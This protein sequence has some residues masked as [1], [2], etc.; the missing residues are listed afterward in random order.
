MV[1]LATLA[2]ASC[3]N[4]RDAFP[5]LEGDYPALEIPTERPVIFS[6]G[7]ICT[8]LNERD[9]TISPDGNEIFY[10]L[11]AGKTVTIMYS[12]FNGKY[13]EEPVVAPFASDKRFSYFEPCF[14]PDGNSVWFL[15][16]MPAMDK[17]PKPGWAYQNIFVS[18]RKGDGT[19]D[20][21]HDPGGCINEGAFQFYPS[22]TR[23]RTVY[24]SRTDPSTGRHSLFRSSY[25][26]GMYSKCERL[27]EPVNSDS[28]MPFNV[29]VSPDESFIIACISSISVE[30][31]PD[32]SNYF[33]FADDGEGGWSGPVPLGPDIN[34]P[35]S[36]AMSSSLSPDG[37]YFF[38]AAQV[39]RPASED[40]KGPVSLSQIINAYSSPQNGNYDIYW[41]DADVI[42]RSA[43]EAGQTAMRQAA[44]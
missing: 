11:S 18:D 27:P 22:V 40:K 7:I 15:T 44:R 10:G 36:N 26:N 42:R 28:V 1:V 21:P 33:I 30:W 13:W 32:R 20:A 25:A 17:E 8:G 37:R 2:S 9:I 6:P 34:I 29:Y 12:R 4:N 19:W 31:N 14:A 24:F 41:V 39:T 5:V 23:S 38:F 43:L 35:G 16:T 3:R